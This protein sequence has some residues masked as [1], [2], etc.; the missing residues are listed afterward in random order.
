MSTAVT[1]SQPATSSAP[2]RLLGG[3]PKLSYF[4]IAIGGIWLFWLAL[5]LSRNL[6]WLG[7]FPFRLPDLASAAVFS[8]GALAGPPLAS[9]VVIA[10]T[11][12]KAG[13]DGCC[14]AVCNGGWASGGT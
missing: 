2:R 12:G 11:S 8:L 14:A 13:V 1:T 4:V 7:I 6:H 10:V 3:H 9:L 5:A